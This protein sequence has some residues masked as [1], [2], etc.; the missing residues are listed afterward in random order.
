MVKDSIYETSISSEKKSVFIYKM[1]RK[2][3]IE[4]RLQTKKE[5]KKSFE[6]L[7]RVVFTISIKIGKK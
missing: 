1:K 2:N 6:C 3:P 4:I 5:N 7:V